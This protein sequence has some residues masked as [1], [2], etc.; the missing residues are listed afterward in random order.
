MHHNAYKTSCMSLRHA[1][2]VALAEREGSGYDLTRRFDRS[3]GFFWSAT[4][5]QIYRVLGKMAADGLA[6]T[7]VEPGHGRPDRRVYSATEAGLAE[8]A[9]WTRRVTPPE[10]PRSEFAVKVRGMNHGDPEAVLADIRRQRDH[11]AQQLAYFEESCTR[12]YPRPGELSIEERPLYAVLRGGIH[13][14]KAL[15]AWCEEML[16][17][18]GEVSHVSPEEPKLAMPVASARTRQGGVRLRSDETGSPSDA[19]TE[20]SDSTD[21]TNFTSDHGR[22]R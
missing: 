19:A 6:T 5:Q 10:V 16:Q 22:T 2:L 3:L 20:P 18:L 13:T 21:P 4:H 15:L 11:H 17:V 12:H 14:E 1:L 7:R 8:L 9:A